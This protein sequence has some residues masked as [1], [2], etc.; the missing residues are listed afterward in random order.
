[1][2]KV[3]SEEQPTTLRRSSRSTRGSVKPVV[4]LTKS[5]LSDQEEKEDP[6]A[7][8]GLD[9]D[10]HIQ[11]YCPSDDDEDFEDPDSKS[12][13]SSRTKRQP[14]TTGSSKK[15]QP[16][17]IKEDK[18]SKK[19]NAQC[20]AE[21][22]TKPAKSSTKSNESSVDKKQVDRDGQDEVEIYYQLSEKELKEVNSAFN[23][24][25]SQ[26]AEELLSSEGLRTA[27]RS[28]GFEPRADEIQKL[29]KKFSNK[30][31]ELNRESFHK[32]MAMKMGAAPGTNDKVL[33]DEISKVF[34]LLDLD[35]T[36]IITFDNLKS[37][38]KE[39]NE[40]ITDEELHEMI[41]EADLDGDFQINKQ[42]FYNIMKK[43]SLY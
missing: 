9:E 14:R 23:I 15:K 32:I 10:E 28:L 27:I 35:K 41:N 42:E 1:M 31:G 4:D 22:K 16:A 43:T 11:D 34:N 29:M 5:E 24:N 33:N 3:K 40:E 18:R 21:S 30:S 38:S 36:G 17:E 12:N 8:K 26:D 19:G 25:C 39:L 7:N 20:K 13:R 2:P 6:K 37:I